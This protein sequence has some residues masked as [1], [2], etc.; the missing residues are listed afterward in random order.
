MP[1][2]GRKPIYCQQYSVPQISPQPDTWP[3][4]KWARESNCQN[5]SHHGTNREQDSRCNFC[6]TVSCLTVLLYDKLL[7]MKLTVTHVS[8]KLFRHQLL[9][10]N[11]TTCH[12][13]ESSADLPSTSLKTLCLSLIRLHWTSS[14]TNFLYLGSV[15]RGSMIVIMNSLF[16]DWIC[17]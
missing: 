3:R 8:C 12:Q 14:C 10:G 13:Q 4:S 15:H 17:T 2:I 16:T 5:L 1:E 6:R 11:W 7:L 9:S